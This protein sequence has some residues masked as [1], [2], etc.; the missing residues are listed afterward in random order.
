[1][2]KKDRLKKQ[3]KSKFGIRLV[4]VIGLLAGLAI[5]SYQPQITWVAQTSA[6]S[7]SNQILPK[8]SDGDG[9]EDSSDNCPVTKNSDQA[10]ADKDGVGDVCDNCLKSSNPDQSD[11]DQDG[12]G[13]VCDNCKGDYNPDQK[14]SDGDRV[15][16]RCDPD[17]ID[18]DGDK[19][20][21]SKDNCPFKFN[22][23]QLDSDK[24]RIGDSC[25]PD[26]VDS[27]TDKIPDY[28]DNCLL[29][30]NPDQKDS[31]GDG[32]GDACDVESPSEQIDLLMN[33]V[34]NAGLQHGIANSLAVKLQAA[35]ASLADD[36]T[37]TACNQINAFINQVQALSG[38]QIDVVL[39][40]AL[41]TK[42]TQ[43][44]TALNCP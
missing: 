21:D 41:I 22:P 13:D 9:V 2:T 43:I 7:H 30:P 14:D 33:T 18:S 24:D 28:K 25:D 15:G 32:I 35:S 3:F 4:L 26:L 17:L 37:H 44:K 16:D 27:D 19:I 40:G 29:V 11:F 39:A 20:P 1:M 23:D 42:A 36:Q 5:I 6:L 34:Q 8:D 10:D 38:N 31:D 12:V